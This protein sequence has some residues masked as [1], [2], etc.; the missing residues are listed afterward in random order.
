MQAGISM[1][2]PGQPAAMMAG[3]VLPG[4]TDMVKTQ[5]LMAA[6]QGIVQQQSQQPLK[7]GQ[8]RNVQQVSRSKA[9]QK[10]YSR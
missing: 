3:T 9:K 5:N 4:A 2:S 7:Q 6:S 8:A 10:T 1:V